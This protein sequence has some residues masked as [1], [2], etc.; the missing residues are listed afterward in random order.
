MGWNSYREQSEMFG[1][2]L[3]LDEHKEISIVSLWETF[4]FVSIYHIYIAHK[5]RRWMEQW[6]FQKMGYK[7]KVNLDDLF[8]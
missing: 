6:F 7:D 3:K 4:P 5:T 8:L 2:F 1:F